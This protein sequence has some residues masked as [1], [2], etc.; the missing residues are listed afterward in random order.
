MDI[1]GTA[2]EKSTEALLASNAWWRMVA[3]EAKGVNQTINTKIPE[4]SHHSQHGKGYW[5]PRLE[6]QVGWSAVISTGRQRIE[7]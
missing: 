7:R 5:L 2:S 4:C 6:N 1:L 3:G